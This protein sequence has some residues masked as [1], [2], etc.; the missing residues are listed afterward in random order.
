[1]KKIDFIIVGQGI[2]GTSIAFRLLHAGKRI[3]VIDEGRDNSASIVSS[4]IINPITGRRF[5]KSWMF[6]DLLPAA[7]LFYSELEGILNIEIIEERSVLRALHNIREENLW[8]SQS[9]RPDYENCFGELVSGEKY[10][11]HFNN[12]V[13]LGQVRNSYLINI[14]L[15]IKASRAYLNEKGFLLKRAVSLS[16][17]QLASR[18][19][20]EDYSA[21]GIIFAE[22][23]KVIKNPMFSNLPFSPAK[24]EA[25]ICNI[26]NYTIEE[27]VKN[28]KFIVPLESGR[29][30]IG[31][32]YEWKFEND[33]GNLDKQTELKQYLEKYLNRSYQVLDSL[34]AIRPSTKDRRP[35]IGRHP[36][37]S[38][39]YLF[40]GLGTKGISLAPY[41]SQQLTS[42][43]LNR[44][45]LQ[46]EVEIVRY[47]TS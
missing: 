2:A 20:Y 21:V 15:L 41:W 37:F 31:S 34:T 39:V 6:D 43:I 28:K 18:V 11:N 38:N 13:A 9:R 44:K 14:A 42:L 3:L 45:D 19:K 23:W 26:D 12:E 46:D 27:I 40:N 36:E 25:L 30:W 47:S 29:C 8:H 35:I 1:M 17:F 4:G 32:T 24:A 16:D 5:V 33:E 22:G 7:L 10:R